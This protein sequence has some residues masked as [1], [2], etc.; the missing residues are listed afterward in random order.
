MYLKGKLSLTLNELIQAK[1]PWKEAVAAQSNLQVA[2]ANDSKSVIGK[3]SEQI[4][5]KNHKEREEIAKKDSL[6]SEN[7]STAKSE[8][9]GIAISNE[10]LGLMDPNVP[11]N[12]DKLGSANGSAM[13]GYT[14]WA[15]KELLEFVAHM[16]NGDISALSQFDV[17]ALLLDYIKRNNL[18]DPHKKSQIICDLRLKNLF[19]KPRLGHIEMLKLI[20]FH[21]L[22]KEDTQK[23]AFIPAG[24]VGDIS[25]HLETDESSINPSLINKNK[26]R[27]TC[28]KGEE[29][30]PQV[31]LDEYAAID[32]H[33]INLIYLRRSLMENLMEDTQK[34]HDDVVGSIVR[35]K[36]T[37]SDQKQDMYRLVHV[38]GIN[39]LHS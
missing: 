31:S 25:S 26:K 17:Q 3:S 9:A 36:I 6:S 10:H 2:N 22:I 23:N 14:E 33:N 34:F 35:I 12:K 15:T 29:K 11:P 30:A 7:Q 16:K 4:E 18:R 5:V 27:K 37:G 24:I 21:F 28:K 13:K 1:N 38:V 32:A 8:N 20:E 19:G 39:A